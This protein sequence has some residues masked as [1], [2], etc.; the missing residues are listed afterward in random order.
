MHGERESLNSAQ[1]DGAGHDAD[2][3]VVSRATTSSLIASFTRG[4][5]CT[6]EIGD[7]AVW[8]L[9]TAKPGNGV[10]LLRDGNLGSY[11]Q[12]DGPQPHLVNIQFPEKV[13]VSEVAIYLDS[14]ADESYTPCRICV[15]VGNSPHELREFTTMELES[16]QGWQRCYLSESLMCSTS[17]SQEGK[18]YIRAFAVQIAVLANH[19]NGRDTHIR[20]IK[21]FGQ[22]NGTSFDFAKNPPSSLSQYASVR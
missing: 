10:D 14:K 16:P 4:N 7:M 13:K 1:E 6:R 17:R 21:I 8:S 9:S 12:S 11:W 15:R 2:D 20:Q 3:G 18:N 22:L 5:E 19:Q